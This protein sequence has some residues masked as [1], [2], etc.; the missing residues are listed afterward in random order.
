MMEV[1]ARCFPERWASEAWR[2]RLTE[3]VPSSSASSSVRRG[4]SLSGP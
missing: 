2:A 4:V 1:L 3:L